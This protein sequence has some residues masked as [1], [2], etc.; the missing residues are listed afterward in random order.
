MNRLQPAFAS[1]TIL[2][3]GQLMAHNGHHD[4]NMM[5]WLAHMFSSYYHILAIIVVAASLAVVAKIGR[6]LWKKLKGNS[7]SETQVSAFS[8]HSRD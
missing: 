8:T 1:I 3:S 2:L 5:M 6:R 4:S 7:A